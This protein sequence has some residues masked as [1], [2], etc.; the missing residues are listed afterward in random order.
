MNEMAILIL[1]P[2]ASPIEKGKLYYQKRSDGWQW[3]GVERWWE[4][5]IEWSGGWN[6]A[7][8]Y[9]CIRH[10]RWNGSHE[11]LRHDFVTLTH[12]EILKLVKAGVSHCPLSK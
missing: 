5:F 3:D 10:A 7:G 6:G 1:D 12:D 8:D 9:P 4:Y 2:P 11:S